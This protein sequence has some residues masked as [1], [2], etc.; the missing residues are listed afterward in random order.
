MLTDYNQPAVYI[1]SLFKYHIFHSTQQSLWLQEKKITISRINSWIRANPH[2]DI[3]QVSTF[4]NTALIKDHHWIIEHSS[5]QNPRV[6]H[7]K[8]SIVV[9]ALNPTRYISSSQSLNT[10]RLSGS[11]SLALSR[12]KKNVFPLPRASPRDD[13]VKSSGTAA[14]CSHG[15]ASG[16]LVPLCVCVFRS[17]PRACV[18]VTE[19]IA[20]MTKLFDYAIR[21]ALFLSLA[22]Y[23][24]TSLY[25]YLPLSF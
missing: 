7:E 4:I 13:A 17:K 6:F 18:Q 5:A 8:T 24:C 1:Q 21:M 15:Y 3:I 11:D 16:E 9:V 19:G 10:L 23:R 22:L 20:R 2:W 25:L 12:C 14:V